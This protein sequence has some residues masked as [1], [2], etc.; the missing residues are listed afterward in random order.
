MSS[1]AYRNPWELMLNITVCRWPLC[2]YCS[3]DGK[4]VKH[5]VI[6]LE[7]PSEFAVLNHKYWLDMFPIPCSWCSPKGSFLGIAW[8]GEWASQAHHIHLMAFEIWKPACPLPTHSALTI[9]MNT[10]VWSSVEVS[11]LI[12]NFETNVVYISCKKS[13]IWITFVICYILF[14]LY[15][16]EAPQEW[17]NI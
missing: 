2:C 3:R 10:A 15:W 14:L 13:I 12:T 7:I 17:R 9:V 4:D 5:F 11:I 16:C 8:W 1:Y 6:Y